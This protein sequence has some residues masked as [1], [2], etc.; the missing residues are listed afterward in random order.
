MSKNTPLQVGRI[1]VINEPIAIE[2]IGVV[3]GVK[4]NIKNKLLF[5]P[6]AL[7]RN[8]NC[9]KSS[10]RLCFRLC[11]SHSPQKIR[12]TLRKYLQFSVVYF[13]IINR[14]VPQ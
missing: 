6:G 12:K 13:N 9:Q 11:F 3:E 2:A 8:H 10:L 5:F 4:I 7:A 1:T 14:C